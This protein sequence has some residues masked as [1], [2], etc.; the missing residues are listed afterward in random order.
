MWIDPY[1]SAWHK[2]GGSKHEEK[3][4]RQT[5]KR[6][7]NLKRQS[8]HA[9][10]I[11]LILILIFRISKIRG[12]VTYF[13]L[14]QPVGQQ[15]KCVSSPFF[16]LIMQWKKVRGK[17][18]TV[19]VDVDL[20][21]AQSWRLHRKHREKIALQRPVKQTGW[22]LVICWPWASRRGM[23]AM[24]KDTL[25]LRSRFQGLPLA[26]FLSSSRGRLRAWH[27]AIAVTVRELFCVRR[28]LSFPRPALGKSCRS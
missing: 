14:L 2:K 24:S 6:N 19:S 26:S 28:R 5:N 1:N 12:K 25:K 8:Q 17:K 21:A 22:R 11:C 10:R 23:A 16:H 4:Q 27:A 9:Q 18:T 20:T 15:G 3:V 7:T 13:S